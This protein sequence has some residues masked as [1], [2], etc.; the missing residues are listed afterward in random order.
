MAFFFL[1]LATW[2]QLLAARVDTHLRVSCFSTVLDG[3][4]GCNF[5]FHM[6]ALKNDTAAYVLQVFPT[7]GW[8]FHFACLPVSLLDLYDLP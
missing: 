2:C 7:G 3:Y 8:H 6:A 4:V 5:L 1:M